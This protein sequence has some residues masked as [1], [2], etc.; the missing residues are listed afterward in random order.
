MW[1]DKGW[2][3]NL[4]FMTIIRQ[5]PLVLAQSDGSGP[6]TCSRWLRSQA[7]WFLW[8]TAENEMIFLVLDDKVGVWSINNYNPFF[9][10]RTESLRTTPAFK[11]AEK[12]YMWSFPRGWIQ[13]VL[14]TRMRRREKKEKGE[15]PD[16]RWW[17]SVVVGITSPC[18]SSVYFV[19]CFFWRKQSLLPSN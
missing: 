5:L 9:S 4:Q 1:Q 6:R 18:T 14:T 13:R 19:L 12:L 17:G 2:T 11:K 7:F 10:S 16:V 15:D 8:S 3:G